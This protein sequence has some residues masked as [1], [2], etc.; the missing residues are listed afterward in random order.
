[1]QQIGDSLLQ[2]V[3]RARAGTT[4]TG[5]SAGS[6]LLNRCVRPLS[7]GPE[8]VDDVT[9]ASWVQDGQRVSW[10]AVS[11][12]YPVLA[13]S[14]QRRAHCASLLGMRGTADWTANSTPFRF[15]RIIVSN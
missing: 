15:V 12:S 14:A 11:S 2:A 7:L 4:W 3:H 8:A 13:P 10:P 9:T 1:M 5:L 6:G